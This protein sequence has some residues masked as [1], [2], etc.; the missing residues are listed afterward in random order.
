[1]AGEPTTADLLRL[2]RTT[3]DV[4]SIPL[5]EA[6][7]RVAPPERWEAV[8]ARYEE[9]ATQVIRRIRGVSADGGPKPWFADWDPASG[10]YWVRQ[11][12]Y[13]LDTVGRTERELESLDDDSDR[14]LSH[15]EHPLSDEPFATRGLVIGYVQSGKTAN[16]SAVI[17]K[18]ADVGYRIVIV[19]TGMH[20]SLRQQTQRRLERELGLVDGVG[21]GLP[22]HGSRWICQTTAALDGDFRPG[23]SDPNVLQGNERVI[24]V[25]KK[26]GTVLDRLI[27]FIQQAKPPEGLPVLIID[28]E[29]DQASINTGGNRA[30]TDAGSDDDELQLS[31]LV[32]ESDPDLDLEEELDPSKINAKI[33]TIINSF[34]RVAYIG[35]T[36]TPFAN[37]LIDQSTEDREVYEDLFPKDFILTL[38]AGP[39]YVGAE[40]LFGREALDGL[41]EAEGLDVIRYVPDADLPAILPV[42]C[43]LED[44]IPGIPESMELAIMD[45]VLATGGMLARIEDE[46]APS[47]ML[48]HTHQRTRVQNELGPQVQEVISRFRQEWRYG[49]EGFRQRLRDR[50]QSE[51]DPVTVRIDPAR[52]LRFEDVDVQID[53]LFRDPVRVMVLNSTNTEDVLDYETEP[54]LKAILVGGNRLSR[55]LT[56]EGLLVSYFVRQSPYYDTLLQMGRWFGYREKIVDLTRLWTTEMLASWF[57]DLALREEEL[58]Q[59]VSAAERDELTPQVVGYRIRTHPAMMVTAQNKMGAGRVRNLSYAGR[60]IQTTRFLLR[61]PEWLERNHNAVKR[62][63][64]SLPPDLEI[65]PS[66]APLWRGVDWERVVELLGDYRTVQDRITFDAD[67]A[68]HY[69]EAQVQAGQLI[70][71]D[72]A[73][74]SLRDPDQALGVVDLGVQGHPEFNA[75][76]RSRLRDDPQSIGALTN[77]AQKSGDIRRGD[78]EIGLTNEQIMIAREECAEDESR[79]IRD[80]LLAQRDPAEGLLV[81]YPIS[82]NSQPRPNSKKR[83]PLFDDPA[84]AR[85]V[86]GLALGFPRSESAA[87]V[88]YMVNEPKEE[89]PEE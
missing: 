40:R 3:M 17:A 32:D 12:R 79:P 74:G 76:S 54:N 78:E 52:R 7:E 88:E 70:R 56:L 51:F 89:A 11:R 13:L 81:V 37:V 82:P 9:E 24:F 26:F 69:I 73:V 72:V 15:L 14:V 53:R 44:F 10:Y 66:G 60:L 39:S 46:D 63:F 43:K 20:N 5:E 8:R 59:Q 71:W 83:V 21:V 85:P 55:G 68:R 23:T 25:V 38:P 64:G 28:D 84:T 57:R 1:L 33:R 27:S 67:A 34:T 36:A 86:I 50:W 16:F 75:I 29:A 4:M 87:T 58:R 42:E 49:G 18:A 47:C 65:D 6:I 61:D 77:P 30:A 22:E 45:W 2:V 48:I 80:A 19:L 31:E 41:P 62:L 35:Y